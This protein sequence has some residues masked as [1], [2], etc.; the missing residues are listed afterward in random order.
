M[1][2]KAYVAF[3]IFGI[4]SLLSQ[5]TSADVHDQFVPYPALKGTAEQML[6][7]F[8]SP[9][10]D[11]RHTALRLVLRARSIPAHLIT[12]RIERGNSTSRLLLYEA[13]AVWGDE[14]TLEV[15]LRIYRP[16]FVHS[17]EAIRLMEN[18]LYLGARYKLPIEFL[19]YL[20]RA[21]L[22]G[23]EY[24][25]MLARNAL[26]NMGEDALPEL[27]RL[28]FSN[29]PST[30]FP[31][32]SLMIEL[33]EQPSLRLR[34]L[35]ESGGAMGTLA[36]DLLLVGSAAEIPLAHRILK[37]TDLDWPSRRRALMWLAYLKEP[38]AQEMLDSV[39][40]EGYVEL[41]CDALKVLY[42]LYPER[43]DTDKDGYAT[44]TKKLTKKRA[45]AM[46]YSGDRGLLALLLSARVEGEL[47]KTQSS[48]IEQLAGTSIK[49]VL[50][51]IALRGGLSSRP[52]I[53]DYLAFRFAEIA[54]IFAKAG[55][56]EAA[57]RGYSHSLE[58]KW[59]LQSSRAL[60]LL[61]SDHS[62]LPSSLYLRPYRKAKM[63]KPDSVTEFDDRFALAVSGSY[64]DACLVEMPTDREERNR[65]QF[66]NLPQRCL[67]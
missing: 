58:I 45:N 13:A 61:L 41:S 48:L 44:G 10:D 26:M 20:L 27:R 21:W 37:N 60:A 46:L 65:E 57:A 39:I 51:S 28:L 24:F 53:F 40:E 49:D 23:D 34:E 43:Y 1:R 38:I 36:L 14:K 2:R 3:I 52:E 30:L 32:M 29:E 31:V 17:K 16:L 62:A 8:E 15:M 54:G 4:F 18:I 63:R 59:D 42:Y 22:E 56:I 9:R 33:G 35:A 25:S 66:D 11:I 19:P 50:S 7:L 5:S 6:D 55:K 47:L 67:F 64:F 12:E